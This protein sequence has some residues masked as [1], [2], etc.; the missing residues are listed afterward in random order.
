M[1]AYKQGDQF[2][3]IVEYSTYPLQFLYFYDKLIGKAITDNWQ[4]R[5]IKR[6][7][8]DGHLSKAE[9]NEGFNRYKVNIQIFASANDDT[10]EYELRPYECVAQNCEEA[11]KKAYKSQFAKETLPIGNGKYLYSDHS[12]IIML[13]VEVIEQRKG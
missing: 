2:K 9:L 4:Y 11:E 12:G 13:K 3:D 5:M 1:A 6:C 7:I 8:A 10:P